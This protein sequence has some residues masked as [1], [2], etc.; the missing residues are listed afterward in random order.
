MNM[1]VNIINLE[2]II[3]SEFF[4]EKDLISLSNLLILSHIY[5]QNRE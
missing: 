4:K 3:S 5:I 2:K 1:V